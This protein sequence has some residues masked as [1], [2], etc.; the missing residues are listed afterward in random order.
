[1]FDEVAAIFFIQHENKYC[2]VRLSQTGRSKVSFVDSGLTVSRFVFIELELY[3]I[4]M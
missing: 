4:V 3:K 1:M 2:N